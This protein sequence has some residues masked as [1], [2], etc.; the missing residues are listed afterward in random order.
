MFCPECGSNLPD[1]ARFCEACGT[2]IVPAE[3][4]S[5]QDAS[6]TGETESDV[7]PEGSKVTEN[8]VLGK[9]GKYHWYYEFKLLKNPTVLLLLWKIFFWTGVG[10]WLMMV[11]I[12]TFSG[13]FSRDFWSITKGFGFGIAGFEVFVAFGYFVYALLQGFKYCVLF[14]MDEEGVTH[15][16]LP[17]QF[18]KAQAMS[19]LLI[20]A[21][22]H[23]GRPGTVGTGMIA[24]SKNSMRSTWE[25]VRSIE[26]FRKRGVIKVNERLNK[27][28]VYAEPADFSFIEDFIK[29]H[30]APKCKVHEK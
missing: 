9:D 1:D 17:R 20:L 5:P 25:S 23:T 10:M 19:F 13:D 28:Q 2:R 3:R 4:V 14:E 12:I 6:S 22:L 7:L 29:S 30:L 18:K 26:I 21:G 24:A 27:N 16:Q 8:I 15:T 11:L